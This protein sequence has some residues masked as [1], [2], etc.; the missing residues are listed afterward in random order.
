MCGDGALLQDSFSQPTSDQVLPTSDTDSDT[1]SSVDFSVV[2]AEHSSESKS[3]TIVKR[4]HSLYH[5]I[6]SRI[7]SNND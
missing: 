1:G 7:L 2:F 5:C 4:L 3:E 6:T